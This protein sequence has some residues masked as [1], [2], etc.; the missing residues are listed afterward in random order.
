VEEVRWIA[1]EA[2]HS[3]QIGEARLYFVQARLKSYVKIRGEDLNKSTQ[4]S[5]PIPLE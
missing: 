4:V 3:N 1:E 2:W 5:G